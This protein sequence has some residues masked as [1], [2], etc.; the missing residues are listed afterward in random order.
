MQLKKLLSKLIK[1]LKKNYMNKVFKKIVILICFLLLLK[2]L[3]LLLF[4]KNAYK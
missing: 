4:F 3:V 2:V 1:T